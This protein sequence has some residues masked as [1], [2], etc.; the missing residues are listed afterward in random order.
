MKLLEE[1]FIINQK[2]KLD[3][4]FLCVYFLISEDKIV[5]VGKTCRG[6]ERMQSHTIGTESKTKKFDS[7]FFI[8]CQDE[9]EMSEL[10]TSYIIQYNP[11]YNKTLPSNAKFVSISKAK[12]II[13][14]R[15]KQSGKN[16][17]YSIGSII[18]KLLRE[19]QLTLYNQIFLSQEELDNLPKEIFYGK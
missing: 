19:K 10:E 13:K 18:N 5:Y 2:K 1:E 6:L 11:K 9:E 12:E 14:E 4:H 16:N 8:K 15:R 7:Y 17:N 3:P